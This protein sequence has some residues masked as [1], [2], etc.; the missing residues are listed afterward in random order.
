MLTTAA[1]RMSGLVAPFL[2]DLG[3][4]SGLS[5][6][7]HLDGGFS[8][9]VV[10]LDLSEGMLRTARKAS[11]RQCD[12]VLA[13]ISQP[14]PFR[15]GVFDGATSIGVLHYLLQDAEGSTSGE[16]LRNLFFSIRRCV[17]SRSPVVFQF[18]PRHEQQDAS[19]IRAVA[20]ECGLLAELVC[21][22]CYRFL[23][24]FLD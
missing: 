15:D 9:F 22:F 12:W 13:D 1:A 2:L 18:F 3:C 20:R 14:L 6:R 11:N 10:G 16:R 5:S 4:G 24:P 21:D 19:A 23:G 8:S 17:Q 7:A